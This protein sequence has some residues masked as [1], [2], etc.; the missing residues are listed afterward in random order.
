MGKA[1]KGKSTAENLDLLRNRINLISITGSIEVV[2]ALNDYI[3]TWGYR[4]GEEL[5]RKY[6]ELLKAMQVDLHVDNDINIDFPQTG[7][8]DISFK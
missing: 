5:N 2:K 1:L 4:Y 3:D 7:L 8:R 6:C